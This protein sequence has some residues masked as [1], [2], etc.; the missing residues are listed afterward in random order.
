MPLWVSGVLLGDLEGRLKA[1]KGR[2]E[3]LLD[4]FLAV[5]EPS[6]AVLGPRRNAGRRPRLCA[7][8]L[9]ILGFCLKGASSHLAVDDLQL[10]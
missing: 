8:L 9:R 7:T 4:P 2:I 1:P 10:S 3:V 6:W 5:L